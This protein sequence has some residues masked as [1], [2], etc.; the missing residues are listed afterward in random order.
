MSDLS[1]SAHAPNEHTYP[2]VRTRNDLADLD[3]CVPGERPAPASGGPSEEPPMLS[4]GMP[5]EK[6]IWAPVPGVLAQWDARLSAL[7]SPSLSVGLAAAGELFAPDM[8]EVTESGTPVESP[9]R[10]E[11]H[12]SAEFW[13]LLT[14]RQTRQPATALARYQCV[15]ATVWRLLRSMRQSPSAPFVEEHLA[16]AFRAV[17][18]L[19]A[20]MLTPEIC[21]ALYDFHRGWWAPYLSK[22][23]LWILRTALGRTLAA[24]PVE[25]MQPFWD[26]LQSRDPMMQRAMNLGLEMLR[27]AHSLPHLLHGLEATQQHSTRTAIVNSLEQ[28]GDP[29]SLGVLTRVRRETATS[30]W[31]LSR[32]IARTIRIIE[33][34]NR[35]AQ[36]RTL[37]RPSDTP[38][39]YDSQLLRP[40]EN[41]DS[42]TPTDQEAL[43]RPA[44]RD[45][46]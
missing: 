21:A 14:S 11:A 45:K 40:A 5:E 41:A 8:P 25:T 42:L 20:G 36:V 23:Q 10:V 15:V 32:Q 22:P 43:L 33:Q 46:K 9:G 7:W 12:V 30:D 27:E 1:S 29:H 44:P 39:D 4:E 19:H 18:A 34:Q 17:R 16:V 2:A 26:G 24:L 35:G 37:L 3:H 31:T 38:P 13:R 28:I 6:D